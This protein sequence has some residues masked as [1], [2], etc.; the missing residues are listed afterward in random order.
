MHHY[1][2][3]LIK[4]FSNVNHQIRKYLIVITLLYE[5]NHTKNT[6]QTNQNK[7]KKTHILTPPQKNPQQSWL[8]RG[9]LFEK[10]LSIFP[11]TLCFIGWIW[12]IGSAQNSGICSAFMA[13]VQRRNLI[14]HLLWYMTSGFYSHSKCR[15]IP[16]PC[17]TSICRNDTLY[18][19]L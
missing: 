15:P 18:N 12:L 11:L 9:L 4:F 8:S 2:N 3:T 19:T 13:I 14:V 6:K 16:S 1:A 7:K 10:K 5:R 17:R